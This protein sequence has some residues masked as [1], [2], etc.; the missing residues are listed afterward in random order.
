MEVL[1]HFYFQLGKINAAEKRSSR[2]RTFTNIYHVR[3]NKSEGP[4]ILTILI[5]ANQKQDNE[6]MSGMKTILR[7]LTFGLSGTELLNTI[8]F[9]PSSTPR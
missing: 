3:S 5:Q 1:S 2:S 7:I 9:C 8:I 4:L 6:E